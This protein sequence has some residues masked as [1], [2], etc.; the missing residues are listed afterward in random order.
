MMLLK[1]VTINEVR[2]LQNSNNIT[3]CVI[4]RVGK[5]CYLVVIILFLNNNS[6]DA[7]SAK[8]NKAL[9]TEA[10]VKL[11]FLYSFISFTDNRHSLYADLDHIGIC[12]FGT[13]NSQEKEVYNNEEAKVIYN[14][15]VIIYNNP[16]KINNCNLVYYLKNFNKNLDHALLSVKKG[17]ITVGEIPF[18]ID[19]GG[20]VGF[21]KIRGKVRFKINSLASRNRGVLFNAKLLELGENT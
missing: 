16:Y 20:M 19:K 5:A 10:E 9:I 13:L 3:L 14:K 18:F 15:N 6:A 2:I 1:S 11:A 21:Y 12:I 8:Q 17:I 4:L 7:N